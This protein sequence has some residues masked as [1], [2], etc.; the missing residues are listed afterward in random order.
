MSSRVRVSALHRLHLEVDGNPDG[1]LVVLLHGG[2]GGL[3]DARDLDFFPA[4]R[5]RRVV[6]HQ[7]GS[8]LSRPLGELTDNSLDR[9]ADD[10]EA[11][12]TRLG[13]GRWIVFGGSFGAAHALHYAE[14]F[15][16][17]CAALVVHSVL[18]GRPGFETWDFDGSRD[19]DPAGWARLVAAIPGPPD[20]PPAERCFRAILDGGPD[21]TRATRAWY[22][23][24]TVLS[25]VSP[26]AVAEGQPR[27]TRG[28]ARAAAR[29]SAHY[30]LNRLFLPPGALLAR[31]GRL[32]GLPGAILHGAEDRNCLPEDARDLSRAWTAATLDVVPGAGHSVHEPAMAG[33]LAFRLKHL[34]A[35]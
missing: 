5:F 13:V 24:S 2:P 22:A 15:R 12:R 17:A 25:R 29:L 30:W 4:E 3:P 16:D 1:Q 26:A 23:R 32:R 34:L 6:F 31:A 33:T 9:L 28:Q 18:L 20:L 21:A 19:I 35:G 10:M 11:I 14:R 27:P 7:R 8:G